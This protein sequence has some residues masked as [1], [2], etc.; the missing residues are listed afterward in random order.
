MEHMDETQLK[1]VCVCVFQASTQTDAL[2]LPVARRCQVKN[3]AV[4]CRPFTLD[5]NTMCQLLHPPTTTSGSA[6]PHRI[7][8]GMNK[9]PS[10][11]ILSYLIIDL[12]CNIEKISS[13]STFDTIAEEIIL[14]TFYIEVEKQQQHIVHLLHLLHLYINVQGT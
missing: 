5:K 10:Y 3:K 9:V 4:L 6:P 14:L 13:F 2:R 11:L 8:F 12:S 1:S 7:S